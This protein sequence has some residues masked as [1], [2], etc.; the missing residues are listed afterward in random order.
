MRR[1]NGRLLVIIIGTAGTLLVSIE[2]HRV[3]RAPMCAPPK[4]GR[5]PDWHRQV[6]NERLKDYEANPDIGE[7]WDVVRIRLRDKLPGR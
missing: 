2:P 1:T 7:S 5:V 6:L 3:G 4:V